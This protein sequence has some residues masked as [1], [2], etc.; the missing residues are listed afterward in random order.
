[1]SIKQKILNQKTSIMQLPVHNFPCNSVLLTYHELNW[2]V[3]IFFVREK[4]VLLFARGQGSDKDFTV[5]QIDEVDCFQNRIFKILN[6][7]LVL[8][9]SNFSDIF[10]QNNHP[11]ANGVT[12]RAFRNCLLPWIMKKLC[13]YCVYFWEQQSFVPVWAVCPFDTKQVWVLNTPWFHCQMWPLSHLCL[14]GEN[15]RMLIL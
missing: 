14:A 7:C 5:H 15:L 1:M 8:Y 3:R 13:F 2:T 12:L 9:N 4:F 11:L 10:P 6:W